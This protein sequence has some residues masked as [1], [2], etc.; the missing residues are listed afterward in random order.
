M[1]RRSHIAGPPL[2][3]TPLDYVPI[4]AP[5]YKITPTV[6]RAPALKRALVAAVAIPLLAVAIPLAIIVGGLFLA[7]VALLDWADTDDAQ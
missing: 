5:R 2:T 7:F 4:D 6:F 3:G 1:T